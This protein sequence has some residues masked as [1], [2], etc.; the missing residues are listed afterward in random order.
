MCYYF[1]L[2]VLLSVIGWTATLY[3]FK[4]QRYSNLP[5]LAFYSVMEST[6][7]LQSF[8]LDDCKNAV[9]YSSSVF[10]M[11]LVA[12]QPFLWNMHRYVMNKK[13]VNVF[14][15][16]SLASFVWIAAYYIRLFKLTNDESNSPK[17]NT[18]DANVGTEF[19][20]KS[21]PTH[22]Y[23]QFPLH[24]QNGFEANFFT[25]LLLWFLPSL[26]EDKNGIKKLVIWVSQIVIVKFTT[27]LVHEYS[28]VWCL[29]SVPIVI[30][31][32]ML[33]LY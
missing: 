24:R 20:T 28:S 13:N 29:F 26:F 3:S 4:K 12:V 7:L 16:A 30:I 14:V 11:F 2:S 10:A 23:W 22:L 25:Y 9:N 5:I 17:S 27:G 18:N 31:L 6:Q 32:I 19:C 33:N 21:G 15:F 1:P 8:Y